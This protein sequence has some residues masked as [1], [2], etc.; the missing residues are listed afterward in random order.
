MRRFFDFI[1]FCE[2]ESMDE[3]CNRF[4][5]R[6]R[7]D[8]SWIFGNI[9]RFLHSQKERVER[10]EIIASTLGN[11]VKTIKMFCDVTDI[12]IQWKKITR[13]LP[14][15]KRYADDRAPTLEE[16]HK[17]IE[18]PDRRMK[19]I[20]YTM[21][22]SGIRVGVWDHLKW[23]HISPIVSRDGKLVAAKINVYAG[24][25]DEYITFITPEAYLSLQS[26]MTYRSACGEHL[27]KD[28]WVMR[29]LECYKIPKEGR[30][31]KD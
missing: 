23:N 11:Y 5:Y 17:I 21:A 7:N 28:S 13:G 22:S 4:A 30:K 3:R 9:L 6:G 16:I 26:W 10:K 19:P 31:R 27:T 14:K 1:N 12:T 29:D 18:Y 20:V 24:E 15:G 2:G 25:D 8:Y